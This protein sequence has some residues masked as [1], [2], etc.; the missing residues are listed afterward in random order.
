MG[1]IDLKSPHPGK[2]WMWKKEWAEAAIPDQTG[3]TA[4]GL[5]LFALIWNAI[6]IPAGL[7]GYRAAMREHNSGGLIALL[8]PFIGL[9]LVI[10]ATVVTMRR[11]K[12]GKSVFK[13]AT[14]PAIPGDGVRGTIHV[15]SAISSAS[16]IKLRLVCVH[17]KTTGTG[18]DRTT[19]E[20][21]LW[22]EKRAEKQLSSR[23]LAG[24][25]IPVNFMLPSSAPTTDDDDRDDARIWRLE[26]SAA[27]S[28][29][30]YSAQFE[31][32]VFAAAFVPG[33][34]APP[35]AIVAEP[36]VTSAEAVPHEPGITILERADGGWDFHFAAGRNKG[37]AIIWIVVMFVMLGATV[38]LAYS[39]L[40][41]FDFS[42]VFSAIFAIVPLFMSVIF[43]LFT[44]LLV[45]MV[46]QMLREEAFIT[47]ARGLLFARNTAPLNKRN[48]EMK[49]DEIANIGITIT[50]SAGKT[51]YYSIEVR[52]RSG[53]PVK[54]ASG[55][56]SKP[57][58]QWIADRIK[59]SLDLSSAAVGQT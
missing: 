8:F 9:C 49:S 56:A 42:D 7:A 40:S 5:W 11:R 44:L 57:A 51:A 18:D 53:K 34:N 59:E 38:F 48:L 19:H 50:A 27:V 41:R 20:T 15:P 28:G 25:E 29:L 26:A 30:D 55:I 52:P 22:E 14:L 1:K 23:G 10:A 46:W 43:G 13:I 39:G 12:F 32:P 21:I 58:A 33:V 6:S 45:M 47:V 36:I 31:V 24:T 54:I 35:P 2:P 16:E 3:A 17:R 37:F 4:A